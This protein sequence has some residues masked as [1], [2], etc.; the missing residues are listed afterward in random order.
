[1]NPISCPYEDS[2]ANAVRTG[3]WDNT[4]KEHVEECPHCR[5]IVLVAELLGNAARAD[6]AESVLPDADQIW[7]NARILAIRSARKRALR[8]LAI[9]EL[10]VRITITLAVA[11]GITWIWF[12]C[13]SLAA[14]FHPAHLQVVQP[15]LFT[16]I[17]LAACLITLLFTKLIQPLLIE[18]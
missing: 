6:A 10:V 17:A 5:E 8:P 1:M 14:K 18:D 15:I 3:R 9:A 7:L 16:A 13:Q 11:A 12:N 2:V 4:I